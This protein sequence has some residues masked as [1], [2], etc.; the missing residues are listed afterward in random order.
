M[1]AQN[2]EKEH[3]LQAK[4]GELQVLLDDKENQL[5]RMISDFKLKEE[6]L[7]KQENQ[8]SHD[9]KDLENQLHYKNQE[10]L[11]FEK[12]RFINLPTSPSSS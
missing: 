11:N 7:S 3:E 1:Q 2:D 9:V 5:Q 4:I 8:A 10:F 12:S 6:M